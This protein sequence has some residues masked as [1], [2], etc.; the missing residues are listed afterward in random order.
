MRVHLTQ[1]FLV[2]PERRG[3]L[4]SDESSHP[5]SRPAS[6][7]K[8]SQGWAGEVT[9][10]LT[11]SRLKR[12]RGCYCFQEENLN[13]SCDSH[14]SVGLLSLCIL[15]VLFA[16]AFSLPGGGPLLSCFRLNSDYLIREVFPVSHTSPK[17]GLGALLSRLTA[18]STCPSTVLTTTDSTPP[19]G[20]LSAGTSHYKVINK[21]L[22]NKCV[23]E[24]CESI[25]L[26][27]GW[28]LYFKLSWFGFRVQYSH[29]FGP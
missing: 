20:L 18:A 29:V 17:S 12:A 25:F 24:F 22:L 8:P 14:N 9:D 3:S 6:C 4:R 7:L 19:L 27:L 10:P 15:A 11:S 13:S 28:L 21:Y 16:I 2:L 5:R 23:Y 26:I 1:P